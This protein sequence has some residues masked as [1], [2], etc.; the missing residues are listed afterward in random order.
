LIIRT[1]LI[2]IAS[3]NLFANERALVVYTEEFPPYNFMVDAEITGINIRLVE[4]ACKKAQIECVFQMLPWNRSMRMALEGPN[5]ALISTARTDE[6]EDL[7]QWVGPFMSGQNCIYKLASRTDID[8]PNIEVAKNYVMG[9]ASDSA[10]KKLLTNLGF[11]EGKN[12]NLYQGKYNV[13]RPFAAQRVDLIIGS[14]T[15]IQ[16]QLSYGELELEEV[17]PVIKIDHNLYPGNYLA[18]HPAI[19]E[20]VVNKLQS[21]LELLISS[22]EADKIELEFVKPITASSP[23]DENV[24]LWNACMRERQPLT[25]Q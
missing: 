16:L 23:I 11:E 21:S 25:S 3:F 6:R 7:F 13:F 14:A 8:I 19:N 5:T 4:A 1:F 9:A 2:F 15:S 24:A 18:L 10:Y 22:G 20:E 12:L 17:V